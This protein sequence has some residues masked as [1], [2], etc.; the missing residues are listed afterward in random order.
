MESNL[1][2]IQ[3]DR[4]TRYGHRVLINNCLIQF[5]STGIAEV[6]EEIAQ[7]LLTIDESLSIVGKEKTEASES[8]N[9]TGSTEEMSRSL[10]MMKVAELKDFCET[11]NLPKEEWESLTKIELIKYIVATT[12]SE[13]K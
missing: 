10:A 11:N 12:F 4:K 1:I 7:S 6:E 9:T 3:T 8:G 2:K 13:K 5:D